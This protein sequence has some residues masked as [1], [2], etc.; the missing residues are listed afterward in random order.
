MSNFGDTGIIDPVSAFGE[1]STIQNTPLIQITGVYENTSQITTFNSGTGSSATIESP[2]F[3]ATS[4]TANGGFGSVTSKRQLNYRAGQGL[5][6]RFTALF[7]TPAAQNSQQA[8]LV[9]GTDRMGFGYNDDQEFGI[10]HWY[11]GVSDI[12]ELQITTTNTGDVDITV[13]GTAY[14][15][16]LTGTTAKE[17]AQEIAAS[18]NTQLGVLHDFFSNDDTVV[19][20][21]LIAKAAGTYAYDPL[22]SGSAGTW[23]VISTGAAATETFILQADWNVDTMDVIDPQ[24]GNVYEIQMQYLGFGALSFYVEDENTGR[25]H[26]VHTIHWANQ[27]TITSA[28]N[29]TFRIGWTAG[30]SP[31]GTTSTTIKGAS[32]AGFIQGEVVHLEPA[33][34]Q[35]ATVSATTTEKNVISIRNRGVFGPHRNRV[36]VFGNSV[37]LSTDSKTVIFRVYVDS[38][39]SSPTDWIYVDKANSVVEYMVDNGDLLSGDLRGAVVVAVGESKVIALSNITPIILPDQEITITAE[40]VSGAATDVAVGFNWQ[41]DLT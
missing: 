20:R 40:V 25:F 32:A 26:L 9:S 15:V 19:S 38:T 10:Y 37:S 39:V 1:V 29:P 4:G 2:L 18:L 16:T 36:E 7:D 33:R 27:N 11:H 3:V 22:A 14:T 28:A 34:S 31:T 30:N 23:S 24:K 21:G 13:D 12:Q 35:I 5:C 8:G 41:E 17:N 6:A